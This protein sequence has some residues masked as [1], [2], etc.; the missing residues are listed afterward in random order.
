MI[1]KIVRV[2][3]AAIL[4]ETASSPRQSSGCRADRIA[5]TISG[6]SSV[7]RSTRLT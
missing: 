1:H 4:M 2:I 6:D 3:D 7:M 5:F